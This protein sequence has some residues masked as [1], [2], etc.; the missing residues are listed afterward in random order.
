MKKIMLVLLL[1]SLSACTEDHDSLTQENPAVDHYYSLKD[2][3]EYGYK[4]GLSDADKEQGLMAKA[5]AMFKYSG[6]KNGV[7]QVYSKQ[8][9]VVTTVECAKPCEFM[10]VMVFAEGIG[11]V[12][13]ER[14]PFTPDTL[15]WT[16]ITDAQNGQ[17][18]QFV[19]DKNG[20]KYNIRAVFYCPESPRSPPVCV[21]PM[22][23]ICRKT[24]GRLHNKCSR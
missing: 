18:E 4:Q 9:S 15:G 22:H 11:H 21:L 8:G 16:V 5:L 14:M 2:G 1:V 13:T 23:P 17:L 6:E 20:R 19:G 7:Y 12:S 24:R 10:K 3:Y